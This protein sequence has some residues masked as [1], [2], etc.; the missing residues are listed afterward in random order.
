MHKALALELKDIGDH[1]SAVAEMLTA[2]Q[3]LPNDYEVK[4]AL[5]SLMPKVKAH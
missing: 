3:M 1:N 4:L 5:Q 2:S